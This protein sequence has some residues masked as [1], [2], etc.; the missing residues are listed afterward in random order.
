MRGWGYSDPTRFIK[1]STEL[2]PQYPAA[3]SAGIRRGHEPDGTKARR[4]IGAALQTDAQYELS[5]L[6]R[7]PDLGKSHGEKS[8]DLA[9]IC[10]PMIVKAKSEAASQGGHWRVCCFACEAVEISGA[11]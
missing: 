2:S 9:L 10:S 4:I 6:G 1:A 3:S 7:E 11:R 5:R 8:V